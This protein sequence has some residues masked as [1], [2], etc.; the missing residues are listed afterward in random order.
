MMDPNY[1]RLQFCRN[2]WLS[3]NGP[4]L[5][6]TSSVQRAVEVSWDQEIQVPYPIEAPLSGIGDTSYHPVVWYR[7]S[8]TIPSEWHGRRVTLHFGAV[9][10]RA[11][12]WVNDQFV[13]AHE[14]GHMPFSAISQ[15]AFYPEQEQVGA[16]RR[17]H[18]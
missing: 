5:F 11:Q 18:A 12:V 1:P 17:V 6:A 10:Y 2:E 13:V 16:H 14:G 7:K 4:W 8:V 3:L 15:L 9:D